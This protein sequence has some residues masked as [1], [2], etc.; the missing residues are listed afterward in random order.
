M[1]TFQKVLLSTL[2]ASMAYVSRAQAQE[3][4]VEPVYNRSIALGSSYLIT[5]D[6]TN[7]SEQPVA[8]FGVN[9]DDWPGEVSS[10]LWFQIGDDAA[11]EIDV[12]F[13]SP[14]VGCLS[15]TA[16]GYFYP[17]LDWDAIWTVKLECT[18][19]VFGLPVGAS[20]QRYWDAYEG[21]TTAV[22]VTP[23]FGPLDGEIGYSWLESGEEGSYFEV[24]YSFN[25]D[26]G[27][28]RPAIKHVPLRDAWSFELGWQF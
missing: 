9:N 17:R 13:S 18:T 7:M 1:R 10:N 21:A 26:S 2:I 25:Q 11:T 3:A 23:S 19:D 4:D 15:A 8:N 5:R 22:F 24:G 27:V 14:I 12:T 6:L 20:H 16:G 28:I